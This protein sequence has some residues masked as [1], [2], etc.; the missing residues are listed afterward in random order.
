MDELTQKMTILKLQDE[1]TFTMKRELEL[2]EQIFELRYVSIY[3]LLFS[4]I[5]L[6]IS[7][8]LETKWTKS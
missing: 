3:H 2:E 4:F 7:S 8:C 1:K 5:F 6:Y